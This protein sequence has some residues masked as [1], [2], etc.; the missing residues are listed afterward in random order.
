MKQLLS[1][2]VPCGNELLTFDALRYEDKIWLVPMWADYPQEKASKPVLMVRI[3]NLSLI[4][5]P[6][7]GHDYAVNQQVPK[8]VVDGLSAEG[9]E[10][11]SG[12]QIT[13]GIPNDTKVVH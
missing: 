9:F 6:P 4:E 8:A 13:F 1:V 10:T 11:L 5:N 12:S 7:S 3:D 2:L